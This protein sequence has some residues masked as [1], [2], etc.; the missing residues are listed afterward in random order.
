MDQPRRSRPAAR[1][2][3][4]RAG[5]HAARC[6]SHLRRSRRGDDRDAP[7]HVRIPSPGVVEAAFRDAGSPVTNPSIVAAAPTRV[8]CTTMRTIARCGRGPAPHRRRRRGRRDD[9]RRHAD[10]SSRRR[11]HR[12]AEGRLRR[13]AARAAGRHPRVQGRRVM[14]R[15][16]PR[17]RAVV[18]EGVG[19]VGGPARRSGGA[20]QGRCVPSLLHARDQPLVGARRARRRRLRRRARAASPMPAGAVL[21]VEPGLYFARDDR[22]SRR[23]CA[24]SA[25][26]SKTTSWSRSA[27]QRC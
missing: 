18:D 8:C 27:V 21:T 4:G 23:S 7:G 3:R 15:P 20:R 13:R 6:G 1:Q 5:G 10:I 22:A 14:G 19:R 2:R 25:C 16:A 26:G 12:A 17:V 24:A 11:V 9:R